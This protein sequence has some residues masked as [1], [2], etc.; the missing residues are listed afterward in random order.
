MIASQLRREFAVRSLRWWIPIAAAM[1]LWMA[2]MNRQSDDLPGTVPLEGWPDGVIA[3]TLFIWT[4]LAIYLLNA[5]FSSRS[6]SSFD[7]GLPLPAR[8]LWLTHVLAIAACGLC[9]PLI[10]GVFVALGNLAGGRAPL[11]DPGLFSI[12]IHEGT[13]L[14][15]SLVVLQTPRPSLQTIPARKGYVAFVM[16]TGLGS[17]ALL[18]LLC[19]LP[20]GWALVPL[21]LA[22]ALGLRTY[23]SLPKS[24]VLVARDLEP[25]VKSADRVTERGAIAARAG[26][27]GRARWSWLVASTI[28][29]NP[30]GNWAWLYLP[31]FVF[32]A[33][34]LVLLIELEGW[35]EQALP[36]IF[37]TCLLFCCWILVAH[38]KLFIVDPLPLSRRRIFAVLMVPPL[39]VVILVYVGVAAGLRVAGLTGP[40]VEFRKAG[41]HN[42]VVVPNN[43]WEVAWDGKL[44]VFESPQGESVSPCCGLRL[45]PGLSALVYKPYHT[46]SDASPELVAWQLSRAVEAVY[47]VSFPAQELRERYLVLADDGSVAPREG[48]LTLL[49][50]YPGLEQPRYKTAFP[51]VLLCVGACRR[52]RDLDGPG[53]GCACGQRS[54]LPRSRLAFAPRRFARTAVGD[55]VARGGLHPLDRLVASARRGIPGGAV[56]VLAFGDSSVRNQAVNSQT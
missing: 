52:V 26:S 25:A 19:A 10:L 48:G 4:A 33:V 16:L 42:C 39:L 51:L 13:V 41:D 1:G 15:L 38:T 6:S 32:Y 9:I 12:G 24:F 17:I 5:G 30:F 37:W 36:M 23:R 20:R 11:L 43:Y 2:A 27:I 54:G 18:F 22:L 47:G 35:H 53:Y 56:A 14:L 21:G 46:P 40:Q 55:D 7:L 8:A 28:W 34:M 50:D 29:R 49:A 45:F 3:A 31:V 44:P